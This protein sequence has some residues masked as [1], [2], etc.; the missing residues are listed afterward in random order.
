MALGLLLLGVRL[1][2][3]TA[4]V[5]PSANSISASGGTIT[6]ADWLERQPAV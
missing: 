2:A 4:V 6:F 5:T 3:Q 1:H